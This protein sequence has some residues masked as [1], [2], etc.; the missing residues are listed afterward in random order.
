MCVKY[1]VNKNLKN[2]LVF[3]QATSDCWTHGLTSSWFPPS[4]SKQTGARQKS[5]LQRESLQ[6]VRLRAGDLGL[7]LQ[8]KNCC[9]YECYK[10]EHTGGKKKNPGFVLL[11]AP[12]MRQTAAG[13]CLSWGQQGLHTHI[14]T[15]TH[16]HTH[17]HIHTHA[18]LCNSN[19]VLHL[20]TPACALMKLKITPAI[21]ALFGTTSAASTV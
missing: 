10:C 5:Y 3:L 2:Y 9:N 7:T 21:R 1:F 8:G 11:E 14:H 19:R 16:T 18:P 17:T 13:R 4:C 6:S 15:H 12:C 20:F